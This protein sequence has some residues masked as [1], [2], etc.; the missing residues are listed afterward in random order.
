MKKVFATSIFSFMAVI[1]LLSVINT[2]CSSRSLDQNQQNILEQPEE[3]VSEPRQKT[4]PSAKPKETSIFSVIEIEDVEY[5][6]L[7][8]SMH[9]PFGVR[10][11]NTVCLAEKHAYLTTERHL[12]VIDVSIPQ[13]PSYLTSL[14]FPD[15]IGKVLAS[16]DYLVVAS[17][18]K[19]HLVNISQPSAPMLQSTTHL[20]DQHAIKDMDV[21]DAYI[22]VRGENNTLYIFSII[23]GRGRIVNTIEL[24]SRWWLLHPKSEATD[25]EQVLLSTWDPI[26]SGIMEPLLSERGFLQLRSSKGEKVRASADFLVMESLRDPTSDLLIGDAARLLDHPASIR[27]G[28]KNPIIRTRF[29]PYNLRRE[30][31]E[32]LSTK[33][34]KPLTRRKPAIA[35]V[36]TAGK[37]QQIAPDPSSETIDVNAKGLIGP[38]T[39][40]QVSRELLYVVTA[41]GFFSIKRLVKIE[42]NRKGDRE[43]FLSIIP[44]QTSRPISIA[45]SE[46]Y[47]YVLAAPE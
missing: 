21:R 23:L 32:H 2:G 15:E 16:G 1:L 35:Y 46:N 7:A 47:A 19:L 17:R 24:S 37:M 8:V 5:P 43:Q 4:V 25:V 42:G 44:L 3:N 6:T 13:R 33:A 18:K 36:V 26:P 28:E 20:P 39:D 40:F 9:L 30:C 41:N 10:P 29:G 38:V 45:I 22:Y 12:H 34:E 14:A 27:R 11:N 31:I